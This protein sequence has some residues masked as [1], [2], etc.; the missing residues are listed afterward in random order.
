MEYVAPSLASVFPRFSYPDVNFWI[1]YV[2]NSNYILNGSRDCPAKGYL[3]LEFECSFIIF[4]NRVFGKRYRQVIRGWEGSVRVGGTNDRRSVCSPFTWASQANV[5]QNKLVW[6]G[7]EYLLCLHPQSS[8]RRHRCS[9]SWYLVWSWIR[10]LVDFWSVAPQLHCSCR[11][12]DEAFNR[13][14]RFIL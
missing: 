11:T 2:S 3:L 1:W 14:V 6:H 4:I 7:F 12:R 10:D 8:H 13:H 9:C 5:L